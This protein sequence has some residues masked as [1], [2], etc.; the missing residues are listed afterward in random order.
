MHISPHARNIENIVIIQSKHFDGLNFN[1]FEV[2]LK[3]WLD[4]QA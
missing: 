2:K 4:V 3:T 1:I